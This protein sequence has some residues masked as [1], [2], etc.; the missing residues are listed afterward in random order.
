MDW[1]G[2]ATDVLKSGPGVAIG[3]LLGWLP[4]FRRL[5]TLYLCLGIM[6]VTLVLGTLAAWAWSPSLTISAN[7]LVWGPF[8][9]WATRQ[10]S[11]PPKGVLQ[12]P[13]GPASRAFSRKQTI[14][15]GSTLAEP[16]VINYV[17]GPAGRAFKPLGRS[18]REDG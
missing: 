5:R 17:K 3:C 18:P 15:S 8:S 9:A 1:S 2:I 16:S 13:I 12:G 7:V 4:M 10:P 14:P 11:R 6:V